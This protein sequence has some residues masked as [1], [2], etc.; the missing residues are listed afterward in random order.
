MTSDLGIKA[1]GTHP[2]STMRRLIPP[3]RGGRCYA[4][5]ATRRSRDVYSMPGGMVPQMR[6]HARAM[7][8]RRFTTRRDGRRV[9]GDPGPIV[10]DRQ[11]ANGGGGGGGLCANT[12]GR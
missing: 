11:P 5:P 3:N 2:A 6:S 10:G 4:I 9:R 7:E 8:G 12:S 1:V